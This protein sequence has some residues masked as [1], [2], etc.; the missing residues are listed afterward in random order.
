MVMENP[1]LRY[2]R[3]SSMNLKDPATGFALSAVKLG[4]GNIFVGQHAII[5]YNECLRRRIKKETESILEA[6][7]EEVEGS[8]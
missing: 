1:D 3:K 4:D 6:S 2:Q 7:L 8:V 5:I